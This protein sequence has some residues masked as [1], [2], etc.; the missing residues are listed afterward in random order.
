MPLFLRR[1]CFRRFQY[2][3]RNIHLKESTAQEGADCSG[4]E[5][6]AGGLFITIPM[7]PGGF[8]AVD[9]AGFIKIFSNDEFEPDPLAAKGYE[10]RTMT[11][12]GDYLYWGTM[13]VGAS[14]GYKHYVEAYPEINEYFI[15][16]T[17]AMGF[18]KVA[19]NPY[20]ETEFADKALKNSWRAAMLFRTDFSAAEELADLK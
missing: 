13:H 6:N 2:L 12:W 17:D 20:Q 11:M 15:T 14:A 19:D 10:M 16:G 8:T 4:M 9:R 5:P 7:P 3:R 18:P 1:F